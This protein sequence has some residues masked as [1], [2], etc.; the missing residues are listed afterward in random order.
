MSSI[1]LENLTNK[2]PEKVPLL[3]R[4]NQFLNAQEAAQSATN[5][6]KYFSV[7]RIFDEVHPSS[8]DELAEILASLVEIGVLEK[9]L[10]VESPGHGGIKD[11][12]SLAS[13]PSVI[14][15][16]NTERN[17]DVTLDNIKLLF[18]IRNS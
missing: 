2:F 10:R 11:Y 14:Y 7:N 5:R 8:N 1:S 16:E 3:R 13:I 6:R 15:D 17:I 18:C 9:I 4:M 12:T